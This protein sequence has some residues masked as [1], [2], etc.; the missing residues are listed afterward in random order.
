MLP[1][2]PM[3]PLRTKPSPAQLPI[4]RPYSLQRRTLT[5][6]SSIITLPS[7]ARSSS[8]LMTVHWPNWRPTISTWSMTAY[9]SMMPN[10]STRCWN[11]AGQFSRRPMCHEHRY[12]TQSAAGIAVVGLLAAGDGRSSFAS[13]RTDALASS[14]ISPRFCRTRVWGNV[15]EHTH[16]RGPGHDLQSF[17]RDSS[18]RNRELDRFYGGFLRSIGRRSRPP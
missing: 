7:E 13:L 15:D 6:R 11:D 14:K 16:V 12:G 18:V 17:F 3:L 10:L 4:T 8:Y 9:F 5:A 2:W 1:A